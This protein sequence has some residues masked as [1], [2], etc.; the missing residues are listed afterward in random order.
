M[1][2]STGEQT[3]QPGPFA[4]LRLRLRRRLS[5]GKRKVGGRAA[6][7]DRFRAAAAG[8]AEHRVMEVVA[9]VAEHHEVGGLLGANALVGAMVDFEAVECGSRRVNSV[10]RPQERLGACPPPFRRP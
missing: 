4:R 2:D 10:S 6:E 8:D 7:E 1:L 9:R 5:F 3:R